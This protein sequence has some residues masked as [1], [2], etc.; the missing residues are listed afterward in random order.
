MWFSLSHTSSYETTRAPVDS[1]SED[2]Q[3]FVKL[4]DFVLFRRSRAETCCH[5]P[6]IQNVFWKNKRVPCL[7]RCPVITSSS[8]VSSSYL[9]LTDQRKPLDGLFRSCV[10]CLKTQTPSLIVVDAELWVLTCPCR[11]GISVPIRPKYFTAVH[12]C[13]DPNRNRINHCAVI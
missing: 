3:T 6:N 11:D 9:R 8:A 2:S 5:V 10:V 7:R 4:L 12:T 13:D 1:V